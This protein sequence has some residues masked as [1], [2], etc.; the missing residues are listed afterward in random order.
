MSATKTLE[1]PVADEYVP[2]AGEINNIV[3]LIC[4]YTVGWQMRAVDL[5]VC[6]MMAGEIK[7]NAGLSKLCD[8]TC[9]YVWDHICGETDDFTP[10]Q[11]FDHMKPH[12]QQWYNNTT[13]E[14]RNDIGPAKDA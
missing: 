5:Q 9:E 1:L 10:E 4:K 8:V 12:L 7:G 2:G 11:L 3:Y 6:Q 14:E 13:V